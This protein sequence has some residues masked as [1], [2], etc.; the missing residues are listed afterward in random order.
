MDDLDRFWSDVLSGDPLRVQTVWSGLSEEER[1]ALIDHL[2]RMRDEP[3]WHS[4]QRDASEEALR[5]I[6]SLR[7]PI[8]A[9]TRMKSNAGKGKV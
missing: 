2:V 8:P 6:D 5:A 7:R 9:P 1:Q 4:A 3:G